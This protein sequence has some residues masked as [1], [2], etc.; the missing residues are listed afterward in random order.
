[1][2][3]ANNQKP[4]DKV[5]AP[6]STQPF[7]QNRFFI[8]DCGRRTL[9]VQGIHYDTGTPSTGHYTA[10]AGSHDALQRNAWSR[11]VYVSGTSDICGCTVIA[12]AHVSPGRLIRR[13]RSKAHII[14]MQ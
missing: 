10:H 2:E 11:A 7:H 14:K 5:T 6:I 8:K 13:P 12:D 1:M 4:G 9:Y 3:E